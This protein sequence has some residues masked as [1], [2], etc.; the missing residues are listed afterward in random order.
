MDGVEKIKG[1][2]AD[3]RANL[4]TTLGGKKILYTSDIKTSTR[5]SADGKTEKIDLPV[6]D[7]LLFEMEDDCWCAARPSGTEP[8][9]KFYFGVKA[10][11]VEKAE[12]ILKEMDNDVSKYL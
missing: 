1:I 7:V 9:M 8:K 2:M 11:S 5:T 6:S 3:I 4:P 12:S 10:D